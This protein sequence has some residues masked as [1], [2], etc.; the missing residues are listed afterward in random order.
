MQQL[1]G[2]K[3]VVTG[4]DAQGQAVVALSGPTPNS[5]PLKAVP[6]TVFHGSGTAAPARPCW[7]TATTPPTS[8]FN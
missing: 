5:F 7:I 4:H 2:F 1:P 8:R 6:G 3:R